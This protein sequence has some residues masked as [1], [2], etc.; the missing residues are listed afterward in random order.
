VLLREGPSGEILFRSPYLFSG[1]F[2]I[3]EAT[4][5]AFD[6]GFF[7]TGDQAENDGDGYLTIVG[8]A[9]DLIRTGGEWVSPAEVKAVL[10]GHPAI[11]DAAVTGV[12]DPD[13]GQVVTAC[14]APRGRDGD[15]GEAAPVLRPLARIA[16]AYAPAQAGEELAAHSHRRAN[17]T[18]VA[19][20]LNDD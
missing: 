8:R 1:Y 10:Q 6:V 20:R 11:A 19:G 14:S 17:S 13:W 2:R 9:G 4:A 15:A 5:R 3:E 7:R 12:A 18:P 16:Q